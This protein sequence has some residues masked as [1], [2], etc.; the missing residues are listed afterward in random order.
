MKYTAFNTPVLS[1]LF[2]W[3]GRMTLKVFG[4]SIESQPPDL[5]KYVIIAAPHTSAWDFVFALACAFV[6]RVEVCW[7]G[8]KSLFQGPLKPIMS[9]LG[10]KSVDRKQSS[11]LVEQT[12]EMFR[13]QSECRIALTPEG[14]RKKVERWR[15]GF[16]HMA[17]G[18]NVPIALGFLDYR[19]KVGGFG[20]LF[21]PTGDLEKDL[22]EIQDF[23]KP[24][25]GK[26][27]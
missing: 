16:Y 5:P 26:N 24:I 6:F 14:T 22:K 27:Y 21:Y 25:K 10:G 23:Y 12:I 7:L 9:W 1:R 8:K 19:R 2:Y 17:V 13:S 20:P 3:I 11:N 18:A 15:T 4:W